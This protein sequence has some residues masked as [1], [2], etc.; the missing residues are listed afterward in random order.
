MKRVTIRQLEIMQGIARGGVLFQSGWISA[1]RFRQRDNQKGEEH[2][3]FHR[4]SA[5]NSGHGRVTVGLADKMVN[6]GLIEPFKPH[7]GV[8]AY[9][10]TPKGHEIL[11]RMGRYQGDTFKV[12]A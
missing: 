12:P 4:A 8:P 11:E 3:C 5:V 9:Q 10:L 6:R 2:C 1:W 7:A